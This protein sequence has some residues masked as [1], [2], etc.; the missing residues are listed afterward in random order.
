MTVVAAA[1]IA[2]PGARAEPTFAELSARAE[3]LDTGIG[4]AA[5]LWSALGSCTGLASELDRRQCEAVRSARLA[6]LKERVFVLDRGS[7]QL[8]QV[9][10]YEP[11]R[12][13]VLVSLSG[14]LACDQP[15]NIDG[16]AFHVVQSP[17]VQIK[18][19]ALEVEPLGE[20]S[21]VF[22]STDQAAVWINS[23]PRRLRAQVLVRVD[24]IQPWQKGGVHGVTVPAL[25]WRVVDTCTGQVLMG[26]SGNVTADPAAC[27][28]QAKP[29]VAAPAPAPVR[30]TAGQLPRTLSPFAV[31]RYM[32]PVRK[33]AQQCFETYGVAGEGEFTIYV[34]SDGRI[35]KIDQTGA[36]AGTPTGDCIIEA[37]R[38]IA[39]PKFQKNDLSFRYPVVLR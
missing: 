18:G 5:A 25:A 26:A 14:C 7:D 31:N 36:F 27:P 16:Q 21:R 17:Q 10:E 32:A 19:G 34:N 30:T 15:L 6:Q 24:R 8:I 37:I 39:F 33:R 38:A 11:K 12:R 9:G 4:L 3:P 35:T 28:E 1:G 13:S 2:E 29:Q 23:A 22:S 20:T